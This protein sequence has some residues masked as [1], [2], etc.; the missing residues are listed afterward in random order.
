MCI[1][2]K[3]LRCPGRSASRD[4]HNIRGRIFQIGEV[5]F[6]PRACLRDDSDKFAL[7]FCGSPGET[8]LPSNKGTAILWICGLCSAPGPIQSEAAEASDISSGKES[9]FRKSMMSEQFDEVTW[10]VRDEPLSKHE[11][12]FGPTDGRLFG[13]RMVSWS[14]CGP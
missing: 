9:K 10:P 7:G 13:S 3:L 4:H 2:N 5:V 11:S 1:S 8:T 14:S 6:Y 12:F